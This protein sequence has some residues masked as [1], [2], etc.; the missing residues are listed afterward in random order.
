MAMKKD[1]SYF[2]PNFFVILISSLLGVAFG[3]INWGLDVGL[4]DLTKKSAI[5][6]PDTETYIIE[7]LLVK[8]NVV[9]SIFGS[10]ICSVFLMLIN[11]KKQLLS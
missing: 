8:I 10:I 11:R 7:M 6:D 9:V 3:Y 1:K 2:I 5:L 4:N